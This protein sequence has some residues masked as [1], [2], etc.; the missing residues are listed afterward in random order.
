MRDWGYPDDERAVPPGSG[1]YDADNVELEEPVE[2][3]PINKPAHYLQ[4]KVE[5]TPTIAAL[6]LDFCEG[7]VVKYVC[8][9]R[10]KNGIEDLKKAQ[11]YLHMMIENYQWYDS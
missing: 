9:H 1:D 7:N 5:V 3:D 11:A 2:H 4:G 10:H 8:R 6:G